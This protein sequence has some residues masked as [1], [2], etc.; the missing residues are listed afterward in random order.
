[1]T[2]TS[3]NY[4][5]HN[6][7]IIAGGTGGRAFIVPLFNAYPLKSVKYFDFVDWAKAIN[8]KGHTKII[9][10]KQLL[11]LPVIYYLQLS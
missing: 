1:M 2:E 10:K 6:F 3:A 9:K 8:I 5:I 4:A 11:K 7:K